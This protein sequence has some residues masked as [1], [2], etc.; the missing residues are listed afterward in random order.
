MVDASK[1]QL[2]HVTEIVRQFTP[3]SVS[4][5]VRARA[6]YSPFIDLAK[7]AIEERRDLLDVLRIP[8][9]SMLSSPQFLLFG[10][11]AG[12]LDEFRPG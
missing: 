5:P 4:P 2:E 10:G 8:L 9:R 7:P 3:P 6:K 1:D 12:K 11:E